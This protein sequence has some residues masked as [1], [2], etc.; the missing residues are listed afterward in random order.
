MV[1]LNLIEMTSDGT[2]R[3]VWLRSIERD[4]VPKKG[5]EIDGRKVVSVSD[6]RMIRAKTD[7]IT[8]GSLDVL[9]Y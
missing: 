6:K 5:D 7:P 1:K 8:D 4:A 3:P 9:I 2:H